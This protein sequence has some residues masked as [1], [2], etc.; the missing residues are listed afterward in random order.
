[1]NKVFLFFAFICITGMHSAVAQMQLATFDKPVALGFSGL[2]SSCV[3]AGQEI[4]LDVE[5]AL[6]GA[7]ISGYTWYIDDTEIGNTKR[8]TYTIQNTDNNKT[9]KVKIDSD[10]GSVETEYQTMIL[11]E[12]TFLAEKNTA[13]FPAGTPLD[14]TTFP[15]TVGQTFADPVIDYTNGTGNTLYYVLKDGSA[16]PY[17]VDSVEDITIPYLNETFRCNVIDYSTFLATLGANKTFFLEP[18]TFDITITAQNHFDYN[19]LIIVGADTSEKSVI[20]FNSATTIRST[21]TK[22]IVWENLIID[23]NSKALNQYFL[24]FNME[25]TEDGLIMKNMVFR[26]IGNGTSNCRSLFNFYEVEANRDYNVR[27]YFINV[28][29]ESAKLY[30]SYDLININ[31]GDGVYIKNLDIQTTTGTAYPITITNGTASTIGAQNIIIDGLSMPANKYIRILRYN[32][33]QISIPEE[34]RYLE[35][36][37]GWDDLSTSGHAIIAVR[38]ANIST[39]TLYAYLDAKTSSYIIRTSLTPVDAKLTKLNALFANT[40][41]TAACTLPVPTIKFVGKISGTDMVIEPF[42]VP[43]LSNIP[44]TDTIHLIATDSIHDPLEQSSMIMF[45]GHATNRI[46]INQAIAGRVK[47]YNVDFSNEALST[48]YHATG[49]LFTNSDTQNSSTVYTENSFYNNTDKLFHNCLFKD[50]SLSYLGPL[51]L[52]PEFASIAVSAVCEGS[53]VDELPVPAVTGTYISGS[54]FWSLDGVELSTGYLFEYDNDHGKSLQYN[55]ETTDCGVFSS[56]G[57]PLTVSRIPSIAFALGNDSFCAGDSIELSVANQVPG[58]TPW[59]SRDILIASVNTAGKVYGISAET[60]SIVYTNETGCQDSVSITVLPLPTAVILDTTYATCQGQS[61]FVDITLTGTSPWTVAFDDGSGSTFTAEFDEASSQYELFPQETTDYVITTVEDGNRCVAQEQGALPTRV[62][63]NPL[64]AVNFG[65]SVSSFNPMILNFS[66][67]SSVNPGVITG[68]NWDFGDGA[69]STLEN[70]QHTYNIPGYYD[71]T[72]TVGTQA[73]CDSS[74]TKTI[75]IK[76]VDSVSIAVNNAVRCLPDN[77][78]AFTGIGVPASYTCQWD[79]GDGSVSNQASPVHYY[80]DSGTFTVSLI[81]SAPAPSVDSDTAYATVKIV[82]IP[83]VRSINPVYCNGEE[84]PAYYF[85]G[86][87]PGTVYMWNRILGQDTGIGLEQTSGVDSI[88]GFTAQNTGFQ[89]L[90]PIYH[91]KPYYTVDG[92]TCAG[93]GENFMITVNPVPQ[94]DDVTD[95]VYYNG[96]AVAAYNFT[97]NTPNTNYSWSFSNYCYV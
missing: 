71:V 50:F 23:G 69:V 80:A 82:P 93:T 58:T 15:V 21:I 78:F 40:D 38:E 56:S 64:P 96:Q 95:R 52:P 94:I 10:K 19:G 46:S 85:T 54:G 28:T 5:V 70:P 74:L 65:T 47:L 1:M 73:G 39:S 63:V 9:I 26:N 33:R 3:S 91:V 66:D 84:V 81:V 62:A 90:S 22:K 4:T 27:R 29:V 44:T 88:P 6:N 51:Q 86:D 11:E 42:T 57:V 87:V 17:S 41:I 92:L 59:L 48:V 13:S 8:C 53:S 24:S 32:S 43:D 16:L 60:T 67:S 36:S 7:T 37:T 55:M 61:V 31:G 97:G 20:R 25:D 72:L 83:N 45:K 49:V 68:Y 76:G 18:G 14:N 75:F 77:S 12:S 34:Y 89:Y 2:S 79:F 35:L 30:F